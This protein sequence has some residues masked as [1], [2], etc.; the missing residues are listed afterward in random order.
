MTDP[1]A[2][3]AIVVD[4]AFGDQ[5]RALPHEM[6]VWIVDT[7]TNRDVARRFWPNGPESGTRSS[8][9]TFVSAAGESPE[10]ACVRI[11][12]TV[13][14]HHNELAPCPPYSAVQV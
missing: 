14:M 4:P 6:P 11:L 5:V 9:S 2:T 13:D 7:P 1:L 3:V 8:V 12:P 10:A